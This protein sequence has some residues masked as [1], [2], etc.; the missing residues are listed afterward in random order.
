VDGSRVIV[1]D[2]CGQV[3]AFNA[4]SG[5]L[6][7]R[8]PVL[9]SD[10]PSW[11]AVA[12]GQVVVAIGSSVYSLSDTNGALQWTTSLSTPATGGPTIANGVVYLDDGT[13]VV[14]LS[15]STGHV[16]STVTAPPGASFDGE[17]VVS[18]GKLFVYGSGTGLQSYGP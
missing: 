1:T 9:A 12:S 7:W 16:L 14:A 10:V 4:T 3:A 18:D 8:T 5:K 17:A 11:V 2:P 15:Q 13:G 6:L